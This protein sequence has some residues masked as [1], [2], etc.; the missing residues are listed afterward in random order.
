MKKTPTVSRTPTQALAALAIALFAFLT[1]EMYPVGALTQLADDL[2][3]TDTQA[4]QLLTVYA[5][6]A[7]VTALPV[8]A[9]TRH[10]DMRAVIVG[11]LLLLTVSQAALAASPAYGAALV[12]RGVAAIGHGV[13]WAGVPV[14]AARLV[15]P[16]R[17]GYAVGIVFLGSSAGLVLGTPL[18]T[19]LSV[20]FGWRVGALLVGFVALVA[21]VLVHRLVPSV[22]PS[23][24][25]QSGELHSAAGALPVSTPPGGRPANG[26]RRV[27]ALCALT[28]VLTGG[29]YVAFTY[30]A[31]LAADLGVVG[32]GW[33][34]LLAAYGLAGMGGV[35]L[36]GR[37]L[38]ARP[39]SV[40]LASLGLVAA[41]TVAVRLSTGA[42]ALTVGFVVW[43]AAFTAV[44]VVLQAG[45]LRV[46]GADALRASAAYVVA[47]QIGISGGA[48]V[49]GLLLTRLG[50]GALPLVTT[51][52]ALVSV[53]MVGAFPVVLGRPRRSR[54]GVSA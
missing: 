39:V 54:R 45:V 15:P 9:L 26:A 27:V 21:A 18:A 2:R 37:Y 42:V 41:G 47:F 8:A 32:P 13:L 40:A 19:L 35:A 12:V 25:R 36:A 33:V 44:P 17:Q 14:L 6:V 51:A 16:G 38:D 4:G 30:L 46:A 34:V 5:V 24:I 11:C 50:A 28:V 43:G 22:G 52:A 3:V 20:G 1:A 49:G 29:H 10:R 7:G 23:V 48:W 31:V 53:V